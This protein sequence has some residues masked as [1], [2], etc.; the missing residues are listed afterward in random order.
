MELRLGAWQ[1]QYF[2]QN[3]ELANI[4][5]L[6]TWLAFSGIRSKFVPLLAPQEAAKV[7]FVLV[8]D[9][10]RAAIR[11]FKAELQMVSEKVSD[12]KTSATALYLGKAFE[13][14]AA[15]AFGLSLATAP[16]VSEFSEFDTEYGRVRGYLNSRLEPVG[17][18]RR[19]RL[20]GSSLHGPILASSSGLRATL[21]TQLGVHSEDERAPA[22]L[23]ALENVLGWA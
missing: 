4:K 18:V 2:N 19:E 14:V 22:E 11:H 15:E 10:G 1:P 17:L 7:D 13:S 6:M 3:G 12:S 16:R 9:A 5:V 23:V 21:L 20:W 8:G